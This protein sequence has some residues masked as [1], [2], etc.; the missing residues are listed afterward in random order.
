MTYY[1]VMQKMSVEELTMVLTSFLKPWVGELPQD[2]ELKMREQI[3][4][5]LKSEVKK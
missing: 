1:E 2:E 3:S 4:E 5:F